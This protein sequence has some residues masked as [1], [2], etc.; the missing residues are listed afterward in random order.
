[1]NRPR[2]LVKRWHRLSLEDL[3]TRWMLDGDPVSWGSD[4]RLTLSFAPDGTH[5]ANA[6]SALFAHLDT[7]APHQVW[8]SA[9]VKAFQTWSQFTNSDVGVVA[10]NGA[11]FGAPGVR[12][13][14]R[15]GDIRIGAMPLDSE[16]YAVAIPSTEIIDG[17]WVGDVL[18]NSNYN[19]WNVDELFAVALHEAGHVFGLP[20]SDDP[21]SPMFTHGVPGPD[22]RVPTAADIAALQANFGPRPLDVYDAEPGAGAVEIPPFHL[23]ELPSG[24]APSVLFGDLTSNDDVDLYRVQ[25]PAGYT[26]PNA[27]LTFQLVVTG[28]SGLAATMEILPVSSGEP[29]AAAT[30]SWRSDASLQVD[31]V[32]PGD[33]FFVRISSAPGSFEVGGYTLVVNFD[34]SNQAPA[35]AVSDLVHFPIRQ[36]HVEQLQSYFTNGFQLLANED[37]GM[38]DPEGNEHELPT[39]PGFAENMHYA[40]DAS[41]E[42][43]GDVDR[44]VVQTPHSV[45]ANADWARVDLRSLEGGEFWTNVRVFDSERQLIPVEYLIHNNQ[46]VTVQFAAE[47]GD[48]EYFV[49]V[50]AAENS[51][52]STGN[53]RL[54]ISF[55]TQHVQRSTFLSGA[56]RATNVAQSHGLLVNRA[57]LFHFQLDATQNTAMVG[58]L[59]MTI[60]DRTNHHVVTTLATAIGDVRTLAVFLPAGRYRVSFQASLSVGSSGPVA[61]HL[62]GTAIDDPLGPR[63]NDP[64][65]LPFEFDLDHKLLLASIF[66]R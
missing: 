8:Q 41:V 38:D 60:R 27:S 55:G 28:I 61:F 25:V 31:L 21:L 53:Y 57:Q 39:A 63:P 11:D 46:S 51:P 52:S 22:S 37:D 36:I 3:E 6:T 50:S 10:D 15:F 16:I 19:F 66:F 14:P 32:S 56:L 1:M 35:S 49:E 29:F 54:E 65:T 45:P 5:V 13:D 62:T 42:S 12:H 33:T 20:H 64:T 43:V 9:I 26:Y 2:I 59:V 17:T 7:V 18:F 44:Y 24:T 58:N 40:I 34:Q 47:Q 30:T 4:A 48:S 23:P